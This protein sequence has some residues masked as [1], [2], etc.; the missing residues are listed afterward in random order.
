MA[1]GLRIVGAQPMSVGGVLPVMGNAALDE[2]RERQRPQTTQP[3]PVLTGLAAHI[4]KC[5]QVSKDHKREYIEHRLLS[6]QRRRNGEY[7]PK[8]KQDIQAQGGSMVFMM[9]TATKCRAAAAWLRDTLLGTGSEKP[10]TLEPTPLPDLPPQTYQD[11]ME[12]AAAR[13]QQ[14][15]MTT[16]MQPSDAEVRQLMLEMRD[17]VTERVKE[18]A[19]RTVERMERKMEDQHVEGG[20]LA[21][22]NDFLEDLVT[23]PYAILK[24]PI[25]RNRTVLSWTQQADGSYTPTTAK[26]LKL[27]W[28]RVSPFDVYWAPHAENPDD[29]YMIERHRLVRSELQ[30]LIG[31]EGYNEEAI[32]EVLEEHGRGGLREWTANDNERAEVEGKG[33]RSVMG[34]NPEAIIEALEFHGS[35]QGRMLIEFGMDESEIADPDMDYNVCAWKIGDKIIKAQLNY[36]PMGRKP[37][38]KTSF[39]KI[40]GQWCGNSVPDLASD[41]QDMCNAAARAL[42]NNMGMSSGPQVAVNVERL[43]DGED[44]TQMYPWKIWQFTNDPMGSTAQPI[45]F[46]APPSMANELMAVY[47]KFSALADEYTGIPRYMQ[48]DSNIGSAG[49]TASGISMLL[50]NASKIIKQVVTN[51]DT[52]VTQP[53]LEYQYYYNMKYGDDPDLKGDVRIR[54]RGALS[55]IQKEAAQV[56]R[57]ELLQLATSN[58]VITGIIGE[59]GVAEILRQVF[60]TA[61]FPNIDKIVPTATALARRQ[62][63]QMALQ[64]Q[65]QQQ[66]AAQAQLPTEQIKAKYDENG[67]FIGA[68]VMSNQGQQLQNGAPVTDN[69]GPMKGV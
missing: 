8:I 49:R 27:E 7:D 55:I 10:W 59:S 26:A 38:Y 29:G 68:D 41:V 36:D 1:T 66:A 32:R 57:N 64:M 21:A 9:I 53:A 28:K 37:Y 45:Q 58:P 22:I 51:V 46:F 14:Y 2:M 48:G 42:A 56:R 4:E 11:L 25:V 12:E 15:M 35:V 24:G 19:R 3:A 43:P 5:W 40:P 20:Y 13:I 18:E 50:G 6:A 30:A 23:F 16:G 34:M 61:D 17:E 31:V 47:E 39:E 33:H 65:Q 54:A 69:F 62:A 52:G 44:V 60:K 67:Q 63:Q